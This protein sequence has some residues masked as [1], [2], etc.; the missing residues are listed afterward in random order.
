MSR[1]PNPKDAVL[2]GSSPPPLGAVVL[3]GIAG[4]QLRLDSAIA[5]QC[6]AAL[7]AALKY[8]QAPDLISST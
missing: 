6:Q 5:A 8:P 4:V 3:G 1:E 7:I 2:G